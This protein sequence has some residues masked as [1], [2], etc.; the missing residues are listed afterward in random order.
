[1]NVLWITGVVMAFGS[2]VF[3]SIPALI[4]GLIAVFAG[5]VCEGI[6]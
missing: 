4:I 3:G 2:L 6:K 5:I 1:M